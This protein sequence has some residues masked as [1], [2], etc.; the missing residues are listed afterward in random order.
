[1]QPQQH[2]EHNSPRK[3]HFAALLS[4]ALPG[5]GQLYNGEFN[6]AI[7]LF[8]IF[9]ITGIPLIIIIALL[10]PAMLTL[11]L[12][13]LSTLLTLGVWAYAIVDGWR[14]A[15]N[16]Q[17]YRVQTWQTSGVYT[18]VFLICAFVILPSTIMW[19]RNHMTQPF[20]IP[21]GSMEP[22][23]M[24]GDFIFANMNYNCPQCL[25]GIKR[26]DVAV[27]VYP[28]NRTLHYIKRVIGLPGDKIRIDGTTI[29]L[30]DRRLNTALDNTTETYDGRS[31]QVQWTDTGTENIY[32]T[33]V[34]SGH[35]FVLGDNRSNSNDSR[36]FGQVPLSD[37][38][39]RARQVWF[40]K[41]KEGVR[42]SRIGTRLNP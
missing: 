38:V 14:I 35:A 29:Y 34:E 27:F 18:L 23:V 6:K 20:H 42:W 26:G 28:D 9:S 2:T 21:S 41:S 22:S 4:L 1:M 40:S 5:L 36:S 3:P 33:V 7:W 24:R 17:T 10:L 8:L 15:K 37:I 39:G 19:V 32:E 13:V 11:P 31:W 12:V 16:R 30:N 25:Q